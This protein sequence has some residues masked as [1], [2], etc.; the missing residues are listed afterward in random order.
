MLRYTRPKELSKEELTSI[1]KYLEAKPSHWNEEPD[2][3]PHLNEVIAL[4]EHIA[5]LEQKY[6]KKNTTY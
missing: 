5:F 4:M 2:H 1:E 6:E 3:D